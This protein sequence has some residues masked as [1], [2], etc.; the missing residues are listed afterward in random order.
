MRAGA[1]SSTAPLRVAGALVVD[2]AGRIF[3]QKRSATRKLF[4]NTWDVVGGHVEAG[5]MLEDTLRREVEEETGWQLA[6]VL[7]EVGDY[8][9]TGEDG[10]ERV[11]TDFLVRV[12]GDRQRP[13]LEAGKHTE[14]RWLGPDDLDVLDEN[15]EIN[16]GMIR[17]L[18]EDGFAVLRMLGL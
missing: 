9:Y 3:F 5:E 10:L 6:V 15:R 18:A 13:R 1:G 12:D 17:R 16:D 14:Y 4:P 8:T 7:G 11:E 2:D